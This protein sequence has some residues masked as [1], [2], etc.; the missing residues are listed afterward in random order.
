MKPIIFSFDFS[1]NKPA[2]CSFINDKIE[3]YFWPSSIDNKAISI[4]ENANINVYNR[5]LPPMR[6]ADFDEHTLILEHVN[7]AG[8]LATLIKDKIIEILKQ[9]NI[10]DY[11]NVIIAN[12]GFAFGAKGD[13]IL[14]LSGYK[15][16][17]MQTLMLAGFKNFKTYSPL[18]LKATSKCNKRGMTKEDMIN[19]LA[20]ENQDMHKLFK[21][22]ANSPQD[23]KKKTSYVVGL[24]DISDSYWCLRTTIKKENINCILSE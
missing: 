15:Y 23:L 20:E 18:S 21:L 7:R 8:N 19:K 22:I 9:H 10:Q 4:L 16:I 1:M 11:S 14:D 24:D 13:A 2:M 6:D 12:E 3:F 17:L 5:E